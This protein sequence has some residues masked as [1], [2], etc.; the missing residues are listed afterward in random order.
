MPLPDQ[1]P[2]QPDWSRLLRPGHLLAAGLILGWL[3]LWLAYQD[4]LIG[5]VVALVAAVLTM[6]ALRRT[7][8]MAEEHE[9]ALRSSLPVPRSL[10]PIHPDYGFRVFSTAL[11]N[12]FQ[13]SS[14]ACLAK[15]A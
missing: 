7:E 13:F 11:R 15:S 9:A 3:A 1:G 10:S 14:P 8:A 6:A 12:A 5:A 2:R 4:Q